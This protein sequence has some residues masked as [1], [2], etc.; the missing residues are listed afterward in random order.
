[1]RDSGCVVWVFMGLLCIVGAVC[2]VLLKG[3]AL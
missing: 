3:G 1:M 2:A